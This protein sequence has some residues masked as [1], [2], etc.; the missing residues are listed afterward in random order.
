M[1]HTTTTPC[2]TMVCATTTSRVLLLLLHYYITYTTTTTSRV[3]LL[4]HGDTMVYHGTEYHGI[5]VVVG[6]EYM[7][8]TMIPLLLHHVCC[9]SG[10][11]VLGLA[12][13]TVFIDLVISP[14]LV[15][16]ILGSWDPRIMV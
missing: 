8:H 15:H 5:V 3:L 14:Y 10:I 2:S 4:H 12:R 7:V 6:S 9:Y 13:I 11:V 16:H 1:V